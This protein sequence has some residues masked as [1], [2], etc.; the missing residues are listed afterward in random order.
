M[1]ENNLSEFSKCVYR[2]PVMVSLVKKYHFLLMTVLVSDI[3]EWCYKYVSVVKINKLDAYNSCMKQLWYMSELKTVLSVFST[4][5]TLITQLTWKC[6]D[7]LSADLKQFP[8]VCSN[9]HHLFSFLC[10]ILSTLWYVLRAKP[11]Y[12]NSIFLFF[13]FRGSADE[14]NSSLSDH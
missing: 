12:Q 9:L 8:L 7:F 13:L 14:D 3:N 10:R 4:S 6:S 1:P 2:I 11:S 5:L